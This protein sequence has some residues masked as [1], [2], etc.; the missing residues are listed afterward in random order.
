MFLLLHLFDSS[1]LQ[2]SLSANNLSE[3]INQGMDSK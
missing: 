2:K 3:E 1:L